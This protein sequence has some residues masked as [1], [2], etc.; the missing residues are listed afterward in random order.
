MM[1]AP[2][3]IAPL[4]TAA[5]LGALA[6]LC[7]RAASAQISDNSFLVEE[8]YNQEP[9][10]VQHIAVLQRD[11]RGDGWASSFTQEWPAGSERHQLSY[12][13]TS[14]SADGASGFGDL[15]LN[16]RWQ[17]L[18]GGDA[19]VAVS[20]R[21]SLLLPTGDE[22]AGR[23]A[24]AAG[25]QLALPVSTVLS[26]SIVAHWNAVFTATPGRDSHAWSAAQSFVWLALPR[27]NVL[28]ETVWTRGVED[29]ESDDT[30]VVS[31]GIRW[32]H[33]LP[34]GLQIVPGIAFPIPVDG[35]GGHSVIAYLS[36]EHPFRATGR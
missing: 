30:L 6:V 36:F 3:R 7:A 34:S 17:A 25:Y 28:V 2:L 31:P 4:L 19:A 22:D 16:Y 18:G 26:P 23:G 1:A 12:T 11:T 5:L 35:G 13:L 29:G 24:G 14:L 21:V 27:F 15:A 10:V 33:D 8:A 32:S 9:G 20:P